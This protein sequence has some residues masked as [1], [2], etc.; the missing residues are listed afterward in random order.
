[1]DIRLRLVAAAPIALAF[2][3][4]VAPTGGDGSTVSRPAAAHPFD[5]C[6]PADVSADLPIAAGALKWPVCAGD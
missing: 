6:N 2:G 1:M 4:L 3:A 5:R